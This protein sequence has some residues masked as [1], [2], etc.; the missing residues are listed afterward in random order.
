MYM[1]I[2]WSGDLDPCA[3]SGNSITAFN[4]IPP[5]NLLSEAFLGHVRR[6]AGDI[7]MEGYF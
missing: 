2:P 1:Y 7:F 3:L 5:Q 6:N 4:T